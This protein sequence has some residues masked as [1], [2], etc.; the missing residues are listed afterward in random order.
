MTAAESER[1]R[2]AEWFRGAIKQAR[3]GDREMADGLLQEFAHLAVNPGAYDSVGGVPTEFLQYVATCI[4]D[5]RKRGYRDAEAWFNVERPDHRPGDQLNATHIDAVR[6]YMVLRVR[7]YGKT[8]AVTGAADYT[9]LTEDQVRYLVESHPE[10]DGL[11]AA[12]KLLVT[13]R[14][15]A[16]LRREPPRKKYQRRV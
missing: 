10:R 9:K 14:L 15:R 4:A 8:G 13:P 6:A 16:I 12:I 5:W 7:G 3:A 1:K 2:L 11:M